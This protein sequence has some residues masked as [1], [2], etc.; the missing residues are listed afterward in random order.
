[1][2][3]PALAA[4][5]AALV[6]S[7][8]AVLLGVLI[9]RRVSE[10]A[11]ADPALLGRLSAIE[12]GQNRAERA[13]REDF[14]LA[15]EETDRTARALREEVT[16]SV[17]RL[18][19]ALAGRLQESGTVQRIAFG[20]FA[21]AVRQTG[22]DTAAGMKE[23]QE[24]FGQRLKLVEDANVQ[25]GRVLRDN[26]EKQMEAQR[27]QLDEF[28]RQLRQSAADSAQR[29][30]ESQEDFGQRLVAI[31][32]T[33]AAAGAALKTSM[34]TQLGTLR[35]ENETKLEQ[36]RATVDEKLQGTLETRLGESF[37]IVS[38][39]LE[40]V[41]K[42]L[43]EMQS[44]A[45]GVGDLKRVLT[46]VKSRGTWGEVQLGAL[47]EQMLAPGQYTANAST[48]GKGGERVEY[49]IRM[50]GHEA[51][52]ILPLDAKFPIEDYERLQHAADIGDLVAVEQASKALETRVKLFAKD[53]CEKYINPPTTT[54]FAILFL[55][56]EGL[57]AEI[58]RRPGL[59]DELQRTFRV[60]I[61]GPTTLTAILS[62]L[63][64]GF[65]T[66]AIQQRSGE[67]WQVLGGV[68]SEFGKFGQVIDGVKRKL[69][70]ATKDIDR[71]GVRKRAIDRRLR[72]VEALEFGPAITAELEFLG[73]EPDEE[74]EAGAGAPYVEAAQ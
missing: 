56:T 67:V 20:D 52:V 2:S 31:N 4:S 61:A 60:T 19:Q 73:L 70:S 46:N 39:R 3:D 65:R 22:A 48:G 21:E 14:R 44:L 64:M 69:D 72:D 51:E 50:P 10:E 8:A 28:A 36:M 38:E 66:L 26:L 11:E 74:D 9:L 62:S 27:L 41:H 16:G 13:Q 55:P 54:D 17:A 34:E 68:K 43:G 37:K 23:T 57:Y 30:K 1:M 42:G 53:I 32:E 6:L 7:L 24:A 35:Q 12:Q 5:V 45:T 47:L 59:S 58:I 25:S 29:Q 33:N 49:A 18:S 63:Q 40:A 15:R 71:I